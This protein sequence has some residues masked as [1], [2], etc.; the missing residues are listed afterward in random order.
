ML[1]SPC[2]KIKFASFVIIRLDVTTTHDMAAKFNREV[3]LRFVL[4]KNM[5]VLQKFLIIILISTCWLNSLILPLRC[6]FKTNRDE[7]RGVYLSQHT[8]ICK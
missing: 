8:P 4:D 5:N 7:N 2:T 6:L 3:M 1:S